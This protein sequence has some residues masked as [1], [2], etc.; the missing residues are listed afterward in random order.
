MNMRPGVVALFVAT[1]VVA[2][3]AQKAQTLS[4]Q[5]IGI[6][7]V[8]GQSASSVSSHQVVTE[9]LRG[10][11]V[12]LRLPDGKVVVVTCTSKTKT[13]WV[14]LAQAAR[15][16]RVPPTGDDLITA[17][18]AG[19]KAKLFWKEPTLDGS[20]KMINETYAIT[21]VKKPADVR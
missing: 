7:E 20:G 18:F 1:S 19:T 10:A 15:S 12:S 16:C 2:L 13:D 11:N 5:V 4:V 21:A 8:N 9:A 14:N 6:E 17:E 3:G